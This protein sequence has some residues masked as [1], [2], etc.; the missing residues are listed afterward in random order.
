MKKLLVVL[1]IVAAVGSTAFAEGAPKAGEVGIQSAVII[2]GVGA[3]VVAVGAKFLVTDAIGLRAAMGILNTSAGG[4]STTAYDLGA[5]F[6]YHFAGKGGV[7][8]YVGAEVGYSGE[9]LSTGAATPSE[10]G[11]NGVFGAEYFFSPNFSWGGEVKLGF[12]S[13]TSAGGAATTF[14]G[15]DAASFIMTW[16]IN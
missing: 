5:G 14:L 11:L 1:F 9:S 10:F 3:S 16:Y 13:A 8:P 6:E 15:T 12:W 4:T 7:S 2:T